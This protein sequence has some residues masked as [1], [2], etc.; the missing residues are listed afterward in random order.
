M[1]ERRERTNGQGET[2][3]RKGEGE[4][5]E[6]ARYSEAQTMGRNM[7]ENKLEEILCKQREGRR[8]GRTARKRQEE[9]RERGRG[10]E[11]DG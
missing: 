11:R 10:R 5:R 4:K 6:G 1:K 9:G 7:K 2:K 8:D 3:G